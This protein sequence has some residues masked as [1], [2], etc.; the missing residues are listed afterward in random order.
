MI[1]LANAIALLFGVVG[2]A[3]PIL[4]Y[5]PDYPRTGWPPGLILL[6]PRH[7]GHAGLVPATLAFSASSRL[8]DLKSEETR[9]KNRKISPTIVADV[10]RFSHQ[11]KRTKFS[12]H[13]AC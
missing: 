1:K 3:L 12:A 8:L 9:F 6:G 4:T 5:E 13:T 7:Y 11:I 2:L 10:K